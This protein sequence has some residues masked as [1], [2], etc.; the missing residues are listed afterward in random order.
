PRLLPSAIAGAL[1]LAAI[2]A[3]VL[4]ASAVPATL[5]EPDDGTIVVGRGA[6]N[7]FRGTADRFLGEHATELEGVSTSSPETV[8][9]TMLG[10][11][12]VVVRGVDVAG[13]QATD[14]PSLLRGRW[15]SAPDEASAGVRAAQVL[16][17]APGDEVLV[18]GA[19][20][21]TLRELRIVGVHAG[22][23]LRDD[24]LVTDLDTAGDLA[25]LPAS[26]V[27]MLRLRAD[28][29]A[30]RADVGN[31]IAVTGL[32][33]E[34]PNPVPHTTATA[35]VALLNLAAHPA[36]RPLT[37]RVNGVLAAATVAQLGAHAAGEVALPFR[38]P[39][40]G[41]LDIQVNPQVRVGTGAAGL[42]VQA[43]ARVA[44]GASFTVNVTDAAGAG[45]SGAVVT[46]RGQTAVADGR[47]AASLLA[48]PAGLLQVT[49]QRG[50]ARG[51]ADVVVADAAWAGIGHVEAERGLVLGSSAVNNSVA[52]YVVEVT[53]VNLGGARAVEDVPVRSAG[54]KEEKEVGA[55]HVD[56]A[57]AGE[58][59][60]NATFFVP[61]SQRE[62]RIAN[63]TLAVSAP[64]VGAVEPVL[65]PQTVAEL[66]DLRKAELAKL[67]GTRELRSEALLSDVFAALEPSVA[68]VVT[69]TFLF[70]GAGV[71]VAVVREVR[72]REGVAHTLRQLGAAPDQLA[73]RAARDA[74]L[75]T[76]PGL[77]L[78][79]ALGLLG[80]A[81][82][83]PRG[84]PAAFGHTIAV[85][86][87]P[88]L[89][90][91]VVG[92]LAILAACAAA[93]ASRSPPSAALAQAPARPLRELL[94][95]E[96]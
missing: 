84:F 14:H 27:H 36:T 51:G 43:P 71:A 18:P 85:R 45:A 89:F 21:A 49:A 87:D 3:V 40:A 26:Q 28:E 1:V 90:A 83:G 48:G 52:R 63:L 81:A 17:L 10:A 82:L 72:E 58:R 54:A 16:A 33:I 53:F 69:A 95:A 79:A 55:F 35:R 42:S 96:P 61:S 7:P 68:V 12:P 19:Y 91:R 50:D 88:E 57:P 30:F 93:W 70:A 4:T 64:R 74:L 2:T 34:P 11:R 32:A 20:R 86:P 5:F 94:E 29:S 23:G 77:V 41:E 65:A 31:D 46:A 24:E 9:P 15:P 76:L 73:M 62:L 25:G 6:G 66:L 47:G 56:L 67:A 60:V 92:G 59:T 80:L 13:W 39:A 37:V 78:G 8:A 75:S 22:A 38:V 44:P